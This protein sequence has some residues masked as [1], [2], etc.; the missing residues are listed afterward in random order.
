MHV[1]VHVL[2]SVC[3]VD[4]GHQ[5]FPGTEAIGLGRSGNWATDS[6]GPTGHMRKVCQLSCASWGELRATRDRERTTRFSFDEFWLGP[7]LTRGLVVLMEQLARRSLLEVR[8]SWTRVL[9]CETRLTATLSSRTSRALHVATGLQVVMIPRRMVWL[10][11]CRLQI[12]LRLTSDQGISR[13]TLCL[14]SEAG[15]AHRWSFPTSW[16]I[17][18]VEAR[19]SC[20]LRSGSGDD[21][22]E[23]FKLSGSGELIRPWSHNLRVQP[24]NDLSR[25][26]DGSPEME[27]RGLMEAWPFGSTVERRGTDACT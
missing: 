12:L 26:A 27:H 10:P 24:R 17:E 13:S 4:D 2:C 8:T 9:V 16:S 20:H 1:H 7:R 23:T 5:A 11:C 19:A 25:N 15:I 18:H 3:M 22:P 6:T 21:G 14:T